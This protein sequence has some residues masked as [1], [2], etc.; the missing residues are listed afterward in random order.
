MPRR[1]AG[2]SAIFDD[3]QAIELPSGPHPFVAARMERDRQVEAEA[4]KEGRASWPKR[5]DTY[6]GRR[7]LRISDALFKAAEAKGYGLEHPVGKLAPVSFR[8]K[9]RRVEWTLEEQS[10]PRQVPLPKKEL[11]KKD[12]IARGIT[13]ETIRVPTGMF[14]LAA[15]TNPG[16][17]KTQMSERI[18]KPFERRIEEV[19]GRFE[20]LVDAAIAHDIRSAEYQRE[21]EEETRAK[22]RPRRLKVM[23]EARW[24]RLRAQTQN[25]HEARSLRTFIDNVERAL[26]DGPRAGRETAWLDWARRRADRIDPLLRGAASARG[27][28]RWRYDPDPSEYELS[29]W[30]LD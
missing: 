11:K 20:K 10:S 1:P 27:I 12:N 23:E 4:H 19:L 6:M 24:D 2:I 15:Q 14:K 25:W 7:K 26:G 8:I 28:T 13:T 5:E 21:Y 17:S 30:E 9:D 18:N 16:W 3:P 22:E 29:E